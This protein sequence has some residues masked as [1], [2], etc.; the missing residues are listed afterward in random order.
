VPQKCCLRCQSRQWSIAA[1]RT[2]AAVIAPN[3]K[4]QIERQVPRRSNMRRFADRK[5]TAAQLETN[6]AL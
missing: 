3:C 6:A 2:A 5:P 1:W 4:L